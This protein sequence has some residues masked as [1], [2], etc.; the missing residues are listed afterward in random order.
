MNVPAPSE[1]AT[2]RMCPRNLS[3]FVPMLGRGGTC[4]IEFLLYTDRTEDHREYTAYGHVC[5]CDRFHKIHPSQL[6][7]Y[8][9]CEVS[10]DF[11]E[12]F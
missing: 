10:L 11:A 5:M 12:D 7:S 9:S 4:M 2:E 6:S 8:P 3:S 1:H